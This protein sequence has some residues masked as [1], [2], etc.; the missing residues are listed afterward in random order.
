MNLDGELLTDDDFTQAPADPY[1]A[2][3]HLERLARARTREAMQ[4]YSNDES[5]SDVQLEYVTAV[6]SLAQHFQIEGLKDL[7]LPA[8]ANFDTATFRYL[9]QQITSFG[10][11]I[12]AANAER[13]RQSTVALEGA[14]KLR[15]EEHV[16]RIRDLIQGANLEPK[17][18]AKLLERLGAFEQELE[19]RRVNYLSFLVFGMALVTGVNE[20]ADFI[21]NVG[22]AYQAAI[23]VIAAEKEKEEEA[24][25][26]ALRV[27]PPPKQ[28]PAPPKP[29]PRGVNPG[30]RETFPADLDDEIPF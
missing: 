6:V 29:A 4:S 10:Y 5:I 2:F 3:A 9:F 14:A 12:R 8:P 1:L 26:A 24:A 15:V 21:E 18:K 22:K 23:T 27:A 13:S 11:R 28:L 20:G 17:R 30:R 19:H 7:E 25:G 16:R